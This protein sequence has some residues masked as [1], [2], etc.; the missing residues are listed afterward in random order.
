M[1]RIRFVYICMECE[2]K[3]TQWMGK[4]NQCQSWNSFEEYKTG[5]DK[6]TK[7]SLKTIFKYNEVPK[8]TKQVFLNSHKVIIDLYGGE[9]TPCH[10]I[11]LIG[12]EPGVGKSTLMLDI[13]NGFL[14]NE[15]ILYVSG[16]E[17]LSQISNRAQRLGLQK[18][19]LYIQ[20]ETSWK[21][22]KETIGSEKYSI[23]VIDSIQ[24]CYHEE[25][26][27]MS[28]S[29]S[30][31]KNIVLELLSIVKDKTVAV[32]LI[33]QV[34]KDGVFAGPKVLEHMVDVSL[35]IQKSIKSSVSEICIHKNRYGGTDK[36]IQFTIEESGISIVKAKDIQSIELSKKSRKGS[37][38]SAIISANS[39]YYIEVES[40]LKKSFNN[41]LKS[42]NYDV[43]RLQIIGAIIERCFLLSLDKHEIY[44]NI[45][46]VNVLKDKN[47]DLAVAVS[48]LTNLRDYKSSANQVFYG[49]LNLFG[50]IRETKMNKGI[51]EIL[52][53]ENL[54]TLFI[55][56]KI[57][58]PH[59]VNIKSIVDLE[60]LILSGKRSAS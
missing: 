33:G 22:I 60:P 38:L 42:Y 55:N 16:E 49:E 9:G 19:E 10:S 28:G 59:I 40:L 8:S 13:C 30:Q 35:F 1:T 23:I 27:G 4:C 54:E 2:Y 34:T 39:Y 43:S 12:G 53:D 56:S 57:E 58:H 24:T 18:N 50:E 46:E 17:S 41:T 15:K 11:S 25:V 37:A 6:T 52:K 36:K 14:N 20:N 45:A 31:I 3:S 48:L 29:V 5:K 51:E 32:F 44:L 47:S 21:K 26:A 7:E